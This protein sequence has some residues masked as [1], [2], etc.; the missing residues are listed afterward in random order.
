MDARPRRRIGLG[1]HLWRYSHR[2]ESARN[3]CVARGWSH[4]FFSESR[5][6][7][8]PIL[9]TGAK[10]REVLSRNHRNRGAIEERNDVYGFCKWEDNSTTWP[11]HAL[12][13][14]L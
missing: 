14:F 6:D 9:G 10:V 3:R 13:T 12:S 11:K 8:S 1:H 4:H 5:L 7:E 2:Q